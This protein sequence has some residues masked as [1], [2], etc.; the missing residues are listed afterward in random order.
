MECI[1]DPNTTVDGVLLKLGGN[2]LGYIVL[3]GP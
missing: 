1:L 2:P 3:R